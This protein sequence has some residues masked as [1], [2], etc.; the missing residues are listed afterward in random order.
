[1]KKKIRWKYTL[2]AA[3][4]GLGILYYLI[5]LFYYEQAEDLYDFPVPF[6][7]KL[8]KEDEH[9]ISYYWSRAS[10]ENGIPFSYEM[11]LKS[12]G[13]EKVKREGASVL[14]RKGSHEIDLT[15]TTNHLY[16]IKIK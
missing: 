11:V 15:S 4:I 10:E 6:T 3:L 13:W 16:I 8:I 2:L 1:M 9:G 5:S 12:N 7:A 14:Y